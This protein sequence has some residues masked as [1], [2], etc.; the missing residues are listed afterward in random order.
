MTAEQII[1]SL[2]RKAD[3]QKARY[4]EAKF[5]IVAKHQLG[6]FHKDLNEMAREIPKDAELA[7]ELFDSGIYEGRLLCSKLFP[8]AQLTEP[9]MDRWT[10]TFENWEVC[11]SFCMTVYARSPLAIPKAIEYS[12]REPEFEKRAGFAIMAALC[13]ADKRAGN[14]VFDK[15]LTIII[16]ESDDNRL[17]VRKAVN[18]ALRSIG[19]RNPDLKRK[20]L[21]IAEQI[22]SRDTKSARWIAK[23]ALKELQKE[24][25]RIANY[26]RKIYG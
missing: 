17:Y 11:D 12:T 3:P 13:S 1:Q 19:K 26:P 2:K 23:D 24:G 9:L 20:A 10:S 16:R 7:T 5:G 8:P 22:A 18:W 14:E 15:F 21:E 4:K 25:L 6:I